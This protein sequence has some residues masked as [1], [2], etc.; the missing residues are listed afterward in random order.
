M[1]KITKKQVLAYTLLPQTTSRVR[2]L[3]SG[4]RFLS[5]FIAQV[6]RAVGLL[7]PGHPYLMSSNMGRYGVSHVIAEAGMLLKR[8]KSA[9]YDQIAI[10]WILMV[11][12]IILAGQFVLLGLG[13]VSPAAH[14]AGITADTNFFTITGA[15]AQNDLAYI[16]LDRVFGVPNLFNSCVATN[17]DCLGSVLNANQ[18]YTDSTHTGTSPSP[19]PTPFHYAMQSIFQLY[20]VALLVIAALILAYFVGAVVAETA[21]SGTPFGQRFERVWAPLRLVT[22]MGLLIPIANGLNSAQYITLYAAKFGSNFA[23]NGWALFAGDVVGGGS[24]LLG[25]PAQLVAQ[26]TPPAVNSL[27]TFFALVSTCKQGYAAESKEHPNQAQIDVEPYLINPRNTA[28]PYEQVTNWDFNAAAQY[29]GYQTIILRFGYYAMDANGKPVFTDATS[30][31]D[32]LCGEIMIP[33]TNANPTQT[34]GAWL[35]LTDYYEGALQIL[36]DESLAAGSAIGD[37]GANIIQHDLPITGA[38]V[39]AP[40]PTAA[41]MDTQRTTYQNELNGLATDA[42]TSQQQSPLLTDAMTEY[43]W[44]GAG[45]WYNRLAQVNGS[46]ISSIYDLP[47]VSKMP[48]VMEEVQQA[49]QQ[50]NRDTSGIDRYRPYEANGQAEQYKNPYDADMAKAEYD[51]YVHW[52]DSASAQ[53]PTG[54]IFIDAINAIFGTSGLFDMQKNTAAGIHPLAQ[55]VAIGRA[56]IESSIHNLGMAAFAGLA[57]G[58][59]NLM[60]THLAGTAAFAVSGFLWSVALTGLGIGFLL[61]Y[62]VP[63]LPFVYFFFAV[64]TWVKTIFEAMVGVPLWALAHLRIDGK[65]LPGDVAMNGY[66]MILEIFL[67]PILIIFGMVGGIAIFTAQT[68]ILNEIW[69]L[70]TSNLTGFDSMTATTGDATGSLNY[71]R[72]SVDQIFFSVVYAVVVYMLALASFKMVDQ[73]PD[74]VLRWMGSSA[75]SYAETADHPGDHLLSYTSLGTSQITGALQQNSPSG[76][77]QALSQIKGRSS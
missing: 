48:E 10:Y 16:L 58:I 61:Y 36:W 33:M 35:A 40:L 64:G 6:Y 9:S 60:G 24:T 76:L 27:L 63:F 22:A 49:N 73:V 32:P 62:I 38:N 42:T 21:E 3:F 1:N 30:N 19:W 20:S 14:A 59:I 11:G 51:T 43:G 70:V 4:F 26:V 53:S 13:L 28:N 77:G 15:Q 66:Y 65:G 55:L 41:D 71:I 68:I 56:I 8:N 18:Y 69:P 37:T 67:R 75:R 31:I 25:T 17:A 2:G 54:N 72:D 46:L 47:A 7:P 52:D 5:F 34:P 74:Y 45:L 50:T 29:S 39:N 12:L 44:G 23:T 57:G